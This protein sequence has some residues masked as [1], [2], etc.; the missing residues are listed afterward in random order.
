MLQKLQAPMLPGEIKRLNADKGFTFFGADE[1]TFFG[2]NLETG[3]NDLGHFI[4][5]ERLTN[6]EFPHLDQP[7]KRFTI[8]HIDAETGEVTRVS[9]PGEFETVEEAR[10]ARNKLRHGEEQH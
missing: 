6:T 4:T 5:S 3:A 7:E 10:T 1:E 9:Q 2:S 8:R